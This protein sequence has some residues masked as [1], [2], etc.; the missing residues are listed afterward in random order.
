MRREIDMLKERLDSS[1]KAWQATRREL[2]ERESRFLSAES[3]A[4]ETELLVRNSDFQ[5]RSFKEQLAGLLSDHSLQIEPFEEQI[6]ERVRSL[7]T[8]YKDRLGVS[9]TSCSMLTN[10]KIY[11]L[12][13]KIFLVSTR[14][15]C[16][17]F[18]LIGV[19]LCHTIV[20]WFCR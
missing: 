13:P 6:R 10:D 14:I 1:Q 17:C 18:C 5:L 16:L 7:M 11:F 20:C 8:D 12:K 19:H 9:D 2:D 3:K 4:K 15:G